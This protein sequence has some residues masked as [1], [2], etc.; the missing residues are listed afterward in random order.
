MMCQDGDSTTVA[1]FSRFIDTF[2]FDTTCWATF[3]E[4]AENLP[5]EVKIF[6]VTW[7]LL[8]DLPPPWFCTFECEFKF[9]A[10]VVKYIPSTGCYHGFISFHGGKVLRRNFYSNVTFSTKRLCES[11]LRIIL[12]WNSFSQHSLPRARGWL[13]GLC[14]CRWCLE[15]TWQTILRLRTNMRHKTVSILWTY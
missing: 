15:T 5:G 1:L 13:S 3:S 14:V 10:R 11:Q 9:R 7:D 2:A 6:H 12:K 8:F 4:D